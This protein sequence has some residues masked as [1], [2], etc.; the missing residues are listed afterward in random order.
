[1]KYSFVTS[2]KI[3]NNNTRASGPITKAPLHVKTRKVTTAENPVTKLAIITQGALRNENQ[4]KTKL[5]G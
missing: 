2:Q 5:K 4:V 3:N 1:M